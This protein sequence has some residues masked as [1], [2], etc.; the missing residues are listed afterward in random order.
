MVIAKRMLMGEAPADPSLPCTTCDHYLH[1]ARDGNWITMDEVR[2]AQRRAP[3]WVSVGIEAGTSAATH[4]DVFVAAGNCVDRNLFVQPP[5]ATRIQ[6]DR[7]NAL[8]VSLPGGEITWRTRYPSSSIPST[9]SC[10]RRCL[11]GL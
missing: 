11:P 1:M 2:M 9:G 8:A 10:I 4:V 5:A 7:Q 6:L 3:T